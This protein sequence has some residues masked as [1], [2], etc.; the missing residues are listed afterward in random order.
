[1]SRN[2]VERLGVFYEKYIQ[3]NMG[4]SISEVVGT[5]DHGVDWKVRDN[6]IPD[7][8]WEP[9]ITGWFGENMWRCRHRKHYLL[10]LLVG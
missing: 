2:S 6:E 9:C 4:E 1:M 8:A 3:G 7:I 10:Q 5:P